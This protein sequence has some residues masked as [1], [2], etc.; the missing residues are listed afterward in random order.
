MFVP[1]LNLLFWPISYWMRKSNRNYIE[2]MFNRFYYIGSH[3]KMR[4]DTFI[5]DDY[6]D[7]IRR[8]QQKV[9]E[10]YWKEKYWKEKY[11]K[12]KQVGE[13]GASKLII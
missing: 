7:K 5:K 6:K 2:I 4:S 3:D 9:A 10:K 1:P 12:E 11:W 13:N 8:R